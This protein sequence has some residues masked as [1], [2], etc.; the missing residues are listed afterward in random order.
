MQSSHEQLIAEQFSNQAAD[1]LHSAVHSQGADLQRLALWREGDNHAR[2]LDLGCG[3]GHA[4]FAAATHVGS[5]VSYDLSEQMLETVAQEAARREL[6]H[7]QTQQGVAESLP[8]A[9]ASFD[10]VIS[11][12]S[13]HHW[14]DVPGA[15]R[16]IHRVLK[17]TGKLIIMDMASSG[18]PVLDIYLQTVEMLRDPSHVRNYSQ[19]EWLAMAN[20]RGFRVVQLQADR[21]HLEFASWVARMKTPT[22]L[23]QAIRM[24]QDKMTDEVQRYFA[25][26]QDGSFTSDTL[27]FLAQRS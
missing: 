1:Y 19:G 16:E 26:Q 11:R 20:S 14:H 4:S 3:A 15:L 23:Q 9:D 24:I 8:F 6:H 17:P 12:Y 5:V 2:L 7:I 18:R 25:I 13:A 21:L 10:V 22:V 27:M